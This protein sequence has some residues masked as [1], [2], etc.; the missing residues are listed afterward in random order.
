MRKVDF[1]RLEDY[2]Y[3]RIDKEMVPG[4]YVYYEYRPWGVKSYG[5]YLNHVGS[6]WVDELALAKYDVMNLYLQYLK[7]YKN[8]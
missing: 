7:D 6:A 5:V 3:L 8:G 2:W 1:V 4:S